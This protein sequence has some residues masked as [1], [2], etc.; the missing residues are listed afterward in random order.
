[1]N[2]NIFKT[3]LKNVAII[4][5]VAIFFIAD[6]YLKQLAINWQSESPVK[7]LDNF[8]T[9]TFTPNYYIAFSLPVSGRILTL[10]IGLIVL[11][12]TIFLGYLIKERQSKLLAAGLFLILLG[13]ISNFIDRLSLGYVVDYLYLKHFTVF[14]L[15]DMYISIGALISLISLK[16]SHKI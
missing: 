10:L 4:L 12:L 16:K 6:R 15:A 1:M 3:S 7:L 14:N 5:L 9:F 2:K 8:F 11:A 13:A